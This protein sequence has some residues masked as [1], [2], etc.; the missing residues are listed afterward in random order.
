MTG[1][2]LVSSKSLSFKSS[3][4]V[5]TVRMF[6]LRCTSSYC[7]LHTGRAGFKYH[8]PELKEHVPK[9]LAFQ[10]N[11]DYDGEQAYI[12]ALKKD[13]RIE[14]FRQECEDWLHDCD[15]DYEPCNLDAIPYSL[16]RHRMFP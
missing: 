1:S 16:Y 9:L 7:T 15:D 12:D 3:I 14:T 6:R 5:L 11:E 4:Q 8:V 2:T 10:N 13:M